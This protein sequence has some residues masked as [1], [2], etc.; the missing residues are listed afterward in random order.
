ME[1]KS[2][3]ALIS[4]FSRAYHSKSNA[5]KIFDDTLAEALLTQEEYA[6]ISQSMSGGI[7]FFNP[8][9]SGTPAAAL[10]WVVDN[11][12]SPTPLGRAAFAEAELKAAVLAGATQYLILGAGYDTFAYRQPRWAKSIQIFE[13]DHPLTAKDKMDRLL[14]A[15]I[16]IPQNLHFI[17]A[18][19]ADDAWPDTLAAA[20]RFANDRISFC[21]ILGVVYYLSKEHFER[22][23]ETLNA[24]LPPNSRIVFDYHDEN[25][26]TENAGERMKK[27]SM[28]AGAAKEAMLAAYSYA[29]MER[30]LDRHGFGILRHLTPA[31]MTQEYFGEYNAAN[32]AN[33]ITAFE[34]TNYCLALKK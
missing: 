34:N 22:L 20:S 26:Y 28:L 19:L 33:V 21:S 11:Q 4:A 6:Q 30:L 3:T 14:A 25:S 16:P 2:M 32:P 27:Q 10:R 5:V 29:D 12:L 15:N 7:Q 9:F 17:H 23:L 13:I 8:A 1:Q 24:I 31:E 18:D